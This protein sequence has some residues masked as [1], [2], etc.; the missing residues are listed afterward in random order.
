M[1]VV[2]MAE[3]SHN[4]SVRDIMTSEVVTMS[5]EDTALEVAKSMSKA[6]IS[7]IIVVSKA[8][9]VGIITEED[10]VRRVIAT[11]LDPTTTKASQ[12]MS[13]PLIHVTL[14][15]SLTDAMRVMARSGIQRVA[16]LKNESLVGIV[17]SR[18][19]LQ[20]SPELIDVLVESL[21]MKTSGAARPYG[22]E[23]DDMV[24]YGGI[25]DSCG[26]YST[27]LVMED[28]RYLCEACRS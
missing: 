11:E 12:I 23:E 2:S 18:D 8:R 17:T 6:D 13:S 9:P 20:W 4:M 25:C 19:I 5:P 22:E 16:V 10:L 7:S 3:G 14:D 1:E 15:T 24:A 21:R 27:D 26:E 28:G